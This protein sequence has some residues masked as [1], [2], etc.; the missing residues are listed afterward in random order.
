MVRYEAA[1]AINRAGIDPDELRR[2][3]ALGIIEPDIEGS[4]S[5]GQIRRIGLVRALVDAGVPLEGLASAMRRGQ[6]SLDFLDAPAFERFSALS[7]VTFE[8]YAERTG[9]PVELF[10]EAF[11]AGLN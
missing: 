10:P 3:V 4:F 7:D 9:T 11:E 8:Q 1:E 6:F 5:G 2:L